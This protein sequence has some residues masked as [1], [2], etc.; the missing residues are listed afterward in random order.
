MKT[1]RVT[2]PQL[3]PLIANGTIPRG[4]TVCVRGGERGWLNWAIAATQRK[5]LK[6]LYGDT[7]TNLPFVSEFTHAAVVNSR[8]T[9]AHLYW[10]RAQIWPWSRYIGK[11]LLFRVPTQMRDP[12]ALEQVAERALED[13]DNKEPYDFADL[14]GF[15][16]RW[17]TKLLFR[18]KFHKVFGRRKKHVCSTRVV[19]WHNDCGYTTIS[20]DDLWGYYPARLVVSEHW[21]DCMLIELTE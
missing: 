17:D 19:K 2:V 1:C 8:Y 4:A 3:Q 9:L 21:T 11:Q 15:L 10:P 14:F 13:V 20:D 6:D 5:A 18:L 12:E 16:V 7:I